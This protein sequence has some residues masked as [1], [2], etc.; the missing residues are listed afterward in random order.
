MS[1]LKLQADKSGFLVGS[2]IEDDEA[3][4][5]LAGIKRD[6][7]AILSAMRHLRTAQREERRFRRA[8]ETAIATGGRA[9]VSRAAAV[10]EG[11]SGA[12][13]L[14][15]DPVTGRFVARQ[16]D[17]GSS[18]QAAAAQRQAR[19]FTEV[20]KAASSVART[21]ESARR[22]S[23]ADS[24]S[25]QAR[26]A[27]GRFGSGDR[28][29]RD[30]GGGLGGSAGAL[31]S[32]AGNL[33]EGTEQ[34]DPLLGAANELK[35]MAAGAKAVWEPIGR[36]GS[37]LFGSRED[38]EQV[39]W[40]RRLWREMRAG[41]KESVRASKDTLKGI[42]GIAGGEGGGGLFGS[43]MSALPMLMKGKGL[44]LAGGGAIVAGIAGWV[45]SSISGLVSKSVNAGWELL[46]K[47]PVVGSIA[48]GAERFA[49]WI[50]GKGSAP[51]KSSAPGMEG[52]LTNAAHAAGVDANLVTAIAKYETGGT[53]DPAARPLRKDGTRMSSAH[54]LGQFTDDTWLDAI[55]RFGQKVG[56]GRGA[57]TTMAEA[58]ALRDDPA[59]QARM[60]AEWT[61]KNAGMARR[62]LGRNDPAA[63]YAL[64]VLGEGD[65]MKFLR[66]IRSNPGASIT[67]VLSPAVIANNPSLFSGATIGDAFGKLGQAVSGASR[68][69]SSVRM[70]AAAVR[71]LPSAASIPA[72]PQ[73]P[74]MRSIAPV[75]VPQA[76]PPIELREVARLS[77]DAAPAATTVVVQQPLGQDVRDRGIAHVATGGIGGVARR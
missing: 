12:V 23:K 71:R 46:K 68:D 59:L 32:G 28:E 72:L 37:G 74:S 57:E 17:S 33:L 26:G 36:A 70:P 30:G 47:T 75:Q 38:K 53:F 10:P 21:A 25:G 40:L 19:D 61:A 7:A 48:E 63:V 76:P 13:R 73:L 5:L 20:A 11:R 24:R 44:L 34:V 49:R 14:D 3:T 9:A 50:T 51:L 67:S 69:I 31:A 18:A 52:V 65:G 62:A 54:G 56:A 35:G 1:E 4:R 42:R 39:G 27:D 16:R 15:R 45:A 58:Q 2:P 60:L 8:R 43:L 55:R 77:S 6:T 64:H 41:R 29:G 22:D 66:A